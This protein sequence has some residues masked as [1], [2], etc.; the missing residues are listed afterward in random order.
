MGERIA[1]KQY[2][3][4]LISEVPLPPPPPQGPTNSQK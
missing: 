1:G 4:S 3:D 2:K